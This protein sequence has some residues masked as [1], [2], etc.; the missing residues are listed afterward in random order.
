MAPARP[1]PRPGD[2]P[3]PP[4]LAPAV[5]ERLAGAAASLADAAAELKRR[6]VLADAAGHCA[7]VRAARARADGATESVSTGLVALADEAAEM[8]QVR[9][10]EGRGIAWESLCQARFNHI[11]TTPLQRLDAHLASSAV[12]PPPADP[13]TEDRDGLSSLLALLGGYFGDGER[14]A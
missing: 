9:V 6:A 1:P 11:L 7:T 2:P 10:R 5:A 3:P 14:E 4:A 8:M 12:P 13:A